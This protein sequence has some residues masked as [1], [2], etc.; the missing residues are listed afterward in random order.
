MSYNLVMNIIPIFLPYAGCKTRCVFCNETEA[1]GQI[2]PYNSEEI[3]EVVLKYRGYFN[4]KKNVELAFYGGSFLN[5]PEES[6][7]EYRRTIQYLLNK[8]LISSIRFSTT[9]ESI[10]RGKIELINEIP[11]S[12]IELGVQSLCEDVLEKSNRPHN[13]H[14]VYEAV[15]ILRENQIDYGIHLMSGL[16]GDTQEKS[17]HSAMKTAELRPKSCRIHP[18]LVLKNTVLENLYEDGSYFPQT[19]EEAIEAVMYMYV[20]LVAHSIKV[21]RMGLCLYGNQIKNVVAGPF[22]ESF[23][24]LVKSRLS[25]EIIRLIVNQLDTRE[26]VLNVD[27]KEKQFFIGY[28]KWVKKWLNNEGITLNYSLNGYSID[29]METIRTLFDKIKRGKRFGFP[30]VNYE[31]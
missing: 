20:I 29:I 7:T 15:K 19:M 5:L 10:S 4:D 12:L 22:H 28:K 16:P 17:I 30:G 11:I 14:D 9:P 27:E 1:T 21:N 6:L 2:K 25:I 3:K 18:T 24:E 26:L 31:A 23:G 8:D 13:V